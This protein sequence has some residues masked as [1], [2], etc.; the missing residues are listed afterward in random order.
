MHMNPKVV[1]ET[2]SR[3]SQEDDNDAGAIL[4]LIPSELKSWMV[5]RL[6]R[7]LVD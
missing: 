2:A 3:G 7:H 6:D 1:A 5:K 4:Y